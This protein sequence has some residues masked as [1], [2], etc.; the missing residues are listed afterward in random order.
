MLIFNITSYIE[1]ASNMQLFIVS[2]ATETVAQ[3][4]CTILFQGTGDVSAIMLP[5]TATLLVE[6]GKCVPTFEDAL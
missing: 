6:S 2:N 4:S 1:V 5:N 3:A